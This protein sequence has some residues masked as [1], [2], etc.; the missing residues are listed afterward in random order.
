MIAKTRDM[1]GS[2]TLARGLAVLRHVEGMARPASATEI[3]TAVGMHRV[4]TLRLLHTLESQGFLRRD[5]ARRYRPVERQRTARIGYCAPLAGT[6]F[7]RAIVESLQRSAADAGLDLTT[8]DNPDDDAETARHNAE[9]LIDLGAR[10]V[11]VFQPQQRVAHA[12]A[13]VLHR[14]AV[15]FISVDSPI[16]GGFYFGANNFEAGKLAGRALGDFARRTWQ[17]RCHRLVLLETHLASHDVEARLSGALAGVREVLRG[18]PEE[19]VLHLDGEGQHDKSLQSLRATLEG[20]RPGTKTLVSC[21]NEPAALGAID[22]VRAL[23]READVAI[24]GQ[25]ATADVHRE[26]ADPASPLVASVAY[27]PERYGGRLLDLCQRV[28]RRE[29][30]PPAVLVE[31]V[32]LTRE[33]WREYYPPA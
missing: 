21:V 27:F 18:F 7:R 23:A 16:P 29:A 14:A 10:V 12:L 32:V 19:R 26:L 1:R 17:G 25:N 15:P 20:Y 31:H 4:S 30:V 13:D 9:L 11:I 2:S 28:L 33:N 3:A 22:A 8:L 6:A 5:G 24:V